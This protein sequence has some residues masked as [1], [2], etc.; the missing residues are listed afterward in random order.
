MNKLL[1]YKESI[2]Q[3]MYNTSDIDINA[4]IRNNTIKY[5]RKIKIHKT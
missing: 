5:K 1:S 3:V 4:Q 2:T